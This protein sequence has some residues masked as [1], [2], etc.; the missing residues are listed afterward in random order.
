MTD[1]LSNEDRLEL[2]NLNLRGQILDIQIR[3]FQK[4]C[5]DKNAQVK[6]KYALDEGDQLNT[7]TG[8]ITRAPKADPAPKAAE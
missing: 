2:V 8:A 1:Q 6:A 7:E 3:A 5:A 4:E